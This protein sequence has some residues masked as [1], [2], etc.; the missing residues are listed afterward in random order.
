MTIRPGELA[1]ESQPRRVVVDPNVLVAA[2][3][4]GS[5]P[6]AQL[7]DAARDGRVVIVASPQLFAELDRVLRREKFRRYVSL[8]DVDKYLSALAILADLIVDQPEALRKRVCRDIDGD[9]LV[10]LARVAEVDLIVSGDRD[11][12]DLDLKDLR[13]VSPREVVER[14]GT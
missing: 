2:L 1:I 7:L 3:I 9:Y 10:A 11:L 4:S 6:P 12:F 13:V 5:G 14:L 8:A